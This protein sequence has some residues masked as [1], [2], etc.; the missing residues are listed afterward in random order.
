MP[1]WC[2]CHPTRCKKFSVGKHVENVKSFALLVN[3]RH[4]NGLGEL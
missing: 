3:A 2:E 1:D 4:Y